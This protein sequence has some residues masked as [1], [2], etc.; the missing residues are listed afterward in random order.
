VRTERYK[1][2][3]YFTAPEEFELYDLASDPAELHNLYGEAQHA[4]L[5]R[6]LAS[7][8]EELR[9]DTGDHYLYQ[10]TVLGPQDLGCDNK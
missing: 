2:I 3:H 10:P 6:Q 7:R 1:Y 4:P 8:L 5:V 9:R